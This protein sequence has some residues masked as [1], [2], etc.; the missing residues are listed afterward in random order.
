MLLLLPQSYQRSLSSEEG[1]KINGVLQFLTNSSK[2]IT[3]LR[4]HRPI[5]SSNDDR[6]VTLQAVHAWF[7]QWEEYILLQNIKGKKTIQKKMIMSDQTREDL[8][9][10]VLGFIKMA[11]N[12]TERM[13]PGSIVPA[14]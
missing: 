3:I 9:S 2:L 13:L 14:E 7:I 4:D 12:I 10:A 5:T 8:S 6:L 1:G 11:K